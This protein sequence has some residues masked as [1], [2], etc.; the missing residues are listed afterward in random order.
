MGG[1]L[2]KKWKIVNG[3]RVL[4]KSGVGCESEP[5]N[6]VAATA[7]APSVDGTRRVLLY[8]LFEDGFSRYL[9][10]RTCWGLTRNW[11]AWDVIRNVK[12]PNNLSDLRFYVKHHGGSGRLDADATMTSLAKMFA[13]DCAGQPATV[14]TA[15]S[16]SS[17]METAG[18]RASPVQPDSDLLT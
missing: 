15:T 16:A 1:D 10:A 8:T 18:D 13:G 3:E 4:L 14:T 5:Y 2:L 11:A 6:E 7:F 17:A 12:Q 9:P